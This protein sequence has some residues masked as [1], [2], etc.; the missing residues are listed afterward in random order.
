[1]VSMICRKYCWVIRRYNSSHTCTSV[2][3]SQNHS[4]LDS[5][6]MAEA[7]KLLVKA[8]PFINVKS[9]I[10]EV[11]SKF[12]YTISYRKAWLEKQKHIESNFLRKFKNIQERFANTRSVISIYKNGV[13]LTLTGKTESY[14]NNQVR[15][16]Y[17]A[18]FRPLENLTIWPAYHGP[19]FVSNSFLRRVTE[20]R[21][22]MTRFLNEM[23]IQMLRDSRHCR[24]CNGEG[25]N[26]SKCHQCS[27]ASANPSSQ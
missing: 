23:D 20:G 14:V 13:R 26:H 19:Q 3:I 18:R 8:D 27:G 1:M 10:A 4:K 24:Q 6:T 17:R 2:T 25:H 9:V 21:S 15:S 7:I 16:V 11:Q 12:N 22:K 5:N